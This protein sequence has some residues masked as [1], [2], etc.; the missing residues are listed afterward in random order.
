MINQFIC[1]QSI[2][3]VLYIL[4]KRA[5]LQAGGLPLD[6]NLSKEEGYFPFPWQN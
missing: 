5:E 3:V 4:L 6:C 2:G 1:L